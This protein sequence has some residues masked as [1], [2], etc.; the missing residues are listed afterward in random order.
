MTR[1]RRRD[2]RVPGRPVHRD[3]GPVRA[4]ASRRSCTA[5][6]A[7]TRSPRGKVFIGDTELGT[8]SERQ[9]T[10]LRRDRVGFVFQAF[11][12]VPTLTAHENITLPMALAGRGTDRGLG[13]PR[14]RHRR[15]A[16]TASTTARRSCRAASS[17][18]WRWPGRSPAGRR[19]SSPTSPPA[20][21]T[22][23]ASAEILAFMRRA[24]DELGQTI[25]MVTHDPAP[26]RTPTTCCSSPTGASSARCPSP[27]ADAVLDRIEAPATAD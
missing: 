15:A 26:R 21:S 8:L 17:S 19:S 9:L 27:D 5:P 13:R 24:V 10:R 20:T 16:A 12:L 6:P 22:A 4:R 2:G 1:P 23:A 25:V 7:S 3:H 11:N 14:H 18:A